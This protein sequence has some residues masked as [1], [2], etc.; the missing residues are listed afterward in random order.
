MNEPSPISIGTR[1]IGP[2]LPCCIMA[3]IGVNH[4]GDLDLARQLID[5]AAACGADVVKF[6][7]FTA[8]GVAQAGAPKAEY[9]LAGTSAEEDQHQMLAR[10]ELSRSDHRLLMDHARGLGLE[11]L[12]TPYSEDDAD[13][14]VDLGV[15]ALKIASGQAV[16]PAFLAHL[17]RKGLPLLL[18]TGM[19]DLDE[20]AAAVDTVRQAGNPPLI[21]FQCT[22][23]YPSALEDTHL[24]AMVAM[25]RRFAVPVGYSDHTPGL[26]ASMTAV[27]LG[28]CIIERHFTLDRSR[29]GPDHAASSDPEELARLIKAVREVEQCLG[30]EH[31]APTEAELRMRPVVRRGIYAADDLPAGHVLRRSD[32]RVARPQGM[33]PAAVLAHLIGKP[34]KHPITRSSPITP[35]DHA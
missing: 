9:Q 20:V 30:S 10:L 11:F 26:T 6:Q 27:A 12:S 24:R 22:T 1:Q 14:L 33:A 23:N 17:A 8:A 32:L 18:S 29:P 15:G 13:F 25:G 4:D 35:E 19:C 16:E 34:L 3:E 2:G 28:A 21:L 7:T 5:Q 31:K